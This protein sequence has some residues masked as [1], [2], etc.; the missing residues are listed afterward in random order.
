[1]LRYLLHVF[2]ILLMCS[3]VAWSAEKATVFTQKDLAHMIVQQFKWDSGLTKTPTDRDYL[4]ILGGKRTYRYEAEAAY[5]ELT[6]RV[7]LREYPL[8]GEFTGKGWIMGVSTTTSSTMTIL[9]PIAGEYDLK[10]RIKG[11]GFIFTVNGV[12]YRA[13]SKTK[14]FQDTEIAKLKLNAGVITIALSIPPEGAIDSFSLVARDYPSVQPFMGWRFKEGLT[15]ARLAET[16]VALANIFDQLPD[17]DQANTPKPVSVAEKGVLPP[18]A[19]LTTAPYLGHFNSQQ[20]VR[21]NYQSTIKVPVTV[22]VTGYYSISANV[23]GGNISGLINDVPFEA[24][25]LPYLTKINLGVYRLEAGENSITFKLP[26]AGGI[27]TIDF[28]RKSSKPEDFM[29]LA[30]V[31]GPAER[32]IKSDESLA[33]LKKLQ[34]AYSIRK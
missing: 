29:K 3:G 17:G 11:N 10:A 1:M 15:A 30:S 18:T 20:W 23:M 14:A 25:S 24:T 31:L 26:V 16:A 9:L 27:D 34:G 2:S 21:S 5:N 33:L 6:D 22:T 7:S 8:F 32:K 19:S 13:D 12:E 4:Q 28:V